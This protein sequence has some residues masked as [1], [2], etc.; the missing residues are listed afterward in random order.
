MAPYTVGH[1]KISYLL[2]EHGYELCEEKRF[3]LYLSNTLEPDTPQQ[4]ELPI[5]HDISEEC[6]LANKV[7]HEDPI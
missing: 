7:K 1:L 2:A 6:A 3:K 4:T 5:A